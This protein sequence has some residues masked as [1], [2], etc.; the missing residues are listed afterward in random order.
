M[1]DT[2]STAA[3]ARQ[4]ESVAKNAAGDMA[5][6]LQ[7]VARGDAA[8]IARRSIATVYNVTNPRPLNSVRASTSGLTIGI[9]ADRKPSNVMAFGGRA[10]PKGVRFA[11]IKGRTIVVSA[12]F[13]RQSVPLVRV[14]RK[15]YPLR[16]IIGPSADKMLENE[17]V[18][19]SI[20]AALMPGVAEDISDRIERGL[21]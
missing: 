2:K 18:A 13:I 16:A 12:G 4:F 5:R 9:N 1:I 7:K 17:T 11:I 20:E 14:S 21:K 15:R 10:T 6:A 19:R 3:L 8:A